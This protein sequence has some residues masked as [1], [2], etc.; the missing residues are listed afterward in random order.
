MA[1]PNSSNK[2][3]F[4][5]NFIWI[6]FATAGLGILRRSVVTEKRMMQSGPPPPPSSPSCEAVSRSGGSLVR[7]RSGFTTTITFDAEKEPVLEPPKPFQVVKYPSGKNQLYGYASPPSGEGRQPAILWLVGGMNSNVGSAPWETASAKND[8]SASAFRDAGMAM[9]YPMLRG[10]YEGAG[11]GEF[12]LGEVDDVIAAAEYFRTLPFVDPS[13][14]YLGGHSTGGTLALLVAAARSDLFR[15]VV[16]FGPAESV[17]GY[18]PPWDSANPCERELR[19]P[20]WFLSSIKTPT[21]MFEGSRGNRLSLGWLSSRSGKAPIS[22][23]EIARSDHFELL[24]PF[25]RLLAQKMMLDT[26][27]NSNIQFKDE[28][29]KLPVPN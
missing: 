28:E 26:S 2:S 20:I 18:G 10:G 9:M 1:F 14:L 17:D 13:R 3:W 21:L 12:L 5:R 11:R 15:A 29:L 22:A 6:V 4:Q 16:A 25:T 7:A 19:S 24:A 8:Q 27:A 23:F